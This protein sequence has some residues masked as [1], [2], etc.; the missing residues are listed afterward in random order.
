MTLGD[1]KFERIPD[2]EGEAIFARAFTESFG[3]P[4]N[5]PVEADPSAV[6][7]TSPETKVPPCLNAAAGI[8]R[9]ESSIDDSGLVPECARR[10]TSMN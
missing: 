3:N 8:E 5:S 7:Q 1:I 9:S 10:K 4:F 6:G 2:E